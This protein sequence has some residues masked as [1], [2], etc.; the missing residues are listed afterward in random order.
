MKM[1]RFYHFARSTQHTKLFSRNMEWIQTMTESTSVSCSAWAKRNY[2]H[3]RFSRALSHSSR[4][5]GLSSSSLQEKTEFRTLRGISIPKREP[6]L[7]QTCNQIN[8]K[9]HPNLQDGL[10]SILTP[11]PQNP[12]PP[13]RA[14]IQETPLFSRRALARYLPIETD[15]RLELAQGHQ[16]EQIGK[17]KLHT[18]LPFCPGWAG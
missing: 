8:P 18:H 11:K 10:P 7:R 16:R 12:E 9:P 13:G 3:S 15:Q 4:N 14:P 17:Y 6:T 2:Q 1:S 5:L